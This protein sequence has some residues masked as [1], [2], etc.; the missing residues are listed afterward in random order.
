MTKELKRILDIFLA[1]INNWNRGVVENEEE[2][3]SHLKRLN[4]QLAEELKK[5]PVEQKEIPGT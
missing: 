3:I 2:F 1:Q 5:P 4:G